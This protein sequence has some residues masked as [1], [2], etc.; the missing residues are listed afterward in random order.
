MKTFVEVASI[1]KNVN[2]PQKKEQKD[3]VVD[4][5]HWVKRNDRNRKHDFRRNTQLCK[6]QKEC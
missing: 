4:L 1:Q 5:K 3:L 6:K 2:H